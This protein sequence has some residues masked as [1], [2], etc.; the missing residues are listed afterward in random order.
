MISSLSFEQDNKIEDQPV[1]DLLMHLNTM[2]DAAVA[3]SRTPSGQN[4]LQQ[5]ILV[6]SD[7]KFHE[8]VSTFV[9]RFA[10]MLITAYCFST[11]VHFMGAGKFEALYQERS[12]QKENDC[13]CTPR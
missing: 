5:L 8:K 2:L 7:G 4:P 10:Y 9:S 3:R 11:K 6:I 13:I 12:K 1:A